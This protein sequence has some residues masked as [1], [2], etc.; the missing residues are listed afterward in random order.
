MPYRHYP[1]MT[2][3]NQP[4]EWMLFF[5]AVSTGLTFFG[6]AP[7]KSL[8]EFM[9]DWFLNFWY[10]SVLLGG[11][12]GLLG[13]IPKRKTR[14]QMNMVL[15][16]ER[17]SLLIII[18]S[19]F[20]YVCALLATY[21]PVSGAVVPLVLIAG[22]VAAIIVRIVQIQKSLRVLKE[23]DESDEGAT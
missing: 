9:P 16:I 3:R 7:P 13:L 19:V 10:I 5:A 2:S 14:R 4:F 11:V 15:K 6:N 20:G 12:I 23:D 17:G 21:R 18:A 22:W 1:F 8:E